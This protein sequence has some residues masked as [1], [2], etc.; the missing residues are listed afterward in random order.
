MA[1]TQSNKAATIVQPVVA[2]H[3][4]TDSME[5]NLRDFLAMAGVQLPGWK[6]VV[7]GFIASLAVGCLVGS[8]ASTV[9][10]IL[11]SGAVAVTGSMFFAWMLYSIGFVLGLYAMFRAGAVVSRYILGGNIDKDAAVAK[12]KVSGWFTF[13][14]KKELR[15]A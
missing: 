10:N 7:M 3:V 6:R 14:S 4:D 1:R 8:V 2:D 15:A 12:N 13:G 9:C 5:F 11:F